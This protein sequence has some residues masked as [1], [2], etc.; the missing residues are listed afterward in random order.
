M[1]VGLLIPL[2]CMM[3]EDFRHRTISIMFVLLF[4][5]FSFGYSFYVY[6]WHIVLENCMLNFLLLLY[7]H[8]CFTI[9]LFIRGKKNKALF[10]E[11]FGIGDALY[12][13]ALTPMMS[14]KPYLLFLLL[15]MIMSLMWW[16]FKLK[17]GKKHTTIPFVGVS[18]FVLCGYLTIQLCQ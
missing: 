10:E 11:Y 14:L 17:T 3:I 13:C 18:G 7:L 6:S 1:T 5:V 16:L 4:F 8:S 2:L 12:L 15:S 9:Y